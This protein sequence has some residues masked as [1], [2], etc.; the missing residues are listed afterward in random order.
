MI[1]YLFF[2]NLLKIIRNNN[3][4]LINKDYWVWKEGLVI[5]NICCFCKVYRVGLWYLYGS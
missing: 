4:L 5:M 1:V 3:Y 2:K